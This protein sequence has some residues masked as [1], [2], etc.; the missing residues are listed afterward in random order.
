M[1]PGRLLA[2]AVFATSLAL[3]ATAQIRLGPVQE[4]PAPSAPKAPAKKAKPQSPL[5]ASIRDLGGYGRI[6]LPPPPNGIYTPT[7]EGDTLVIALPSGTRFVDPGRRP[8]NALSM[9]WEQS[10]IEVVA[11]PGALFRV[12]QAGQGLVVDLIDPAPSPPL[13]AKE[14]PAALPA[15][16]LDAYAPAT[17]LAV[18]A[19][20]L[21]SYAPTAQSAQ[22]TPLQPALAAPPTASPDHASARPDVPNLPSPAR[23][24]VRPSALP[25]LGL[26]A[27]RSIAIEAVP[28]ASDPSILLPAAQGVGLA[29][30]RSG[31]ETLFVLDEPIDYQAFPP[32]LAPVFARISSSRTQDATVVRIPGD[33]PEFRLSRGARGWIVAAGPPLVPIDSIAARLVETSPN[34][35]SMRFAMSEPSRVVTVMDPETGGTLLVGTQAVAGQAS[36][37]ERMHVQ[38]V[39]VPTLQGLV[40]APNLDDIR[41]RREADGFGLSAGPV[42]GGTILRGVDARASAAA[43]VPS[44]SRLFD[45]PV[46]SVQG[47]YDTLNERVVVAGRAA[48]L[49]R[50]EPRLRVAEAMVALGLGVEAQSVLDV[51]AAADPSFATQPQALGLSAVAALLAHRLDRTGT[52]SDAS[53]NGTQEI[54][55]W[56]ALLKVEQDEVSPGDARDLA[57]GLPIL[58]AYPQPLRDRLLPVALE[59]MAIHGQAE[60]AAAALNGLRGD[61]QLDLARGMAL[62]MTNHA[63]EA[64][65]IYDQIS[66]RPDRLPRYKA[67][68]RAVELRLKGGQTDA[69]GAADALDKAIY[70]WRGSRQELSL[71]VRV[72]GLRRQAGQWQQALAVLRDGKAA[73]PEDQAQVDREMA[74]TFAALLTGDA[75]ERMGPAEFV[76]LYDQNQDLVRGMTWDD[77][78]GTKFAE[79]LIALGLQ[80]RA[81]PI[82]AGLVT[83]ASDDGRRVLLGLRLASLRMTLNDPAGALGALADS[84]PPPGLPVD[85]PLVEA[86]QLL[87]ARAESER[88]NKDAALSMLASLPSAA[89]DEVRAD[90]YAS[91]GDWPHAVEA[92]ASLERRRILTS[93]LAVDGQALVMRLAVAA[94]LASDAATLARLAASYGPSMSKSPSAGLFQ[95][96][97]SAPVRGTGDLPRAFQEIQAAR[98]VQGSVSGPKLP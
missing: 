57:S 64:L 81:E 52:M 17:Q 33:A 8:R 13:A 11:V 30:F 66:A 87:Y 7:E 75:A 56:R 84:V 89:S 15:P 36:L 68:V 37:G 32:S 9:K 55:L 38:F 22:P 45:L 31:A 40:V 76:A 6:T 51:A 77:R 93:D 42:A 95:L 92:L 70:S 71:R 96:M 46:D 58:L 74:A 41:L 67:I 34:V 35:L 28:G 73:F 62:E 26:P 97:T 4:L 27:R 18:P 3:P 94:T 80:G 29:V 44:Q 19:P 12:R 65:S 16:P 53:L 79:Q 98:Q 72:A 43:F 88:G 90:I 83:R 39:L 78:T 21:D 85:P 86:R 2:A 1:M 63:P 10:R 48:A 24:E 25:A 49:A 23:A 5:R 14:P 82:M 20:S 60:A 50:S 69:K 91:R 54:E 59:A 61:Q 47:L